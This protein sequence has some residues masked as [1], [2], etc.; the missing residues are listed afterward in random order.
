MPLSATRLLS[1]GSLVRDPARLPLRALLRSRMLRFLGL[2]LLAMPA[3]AATVPS[4]VTRPVDT[5]LVTQLVQH[6]PAWANPANLAAAVPEDQNFEQMTLVLARPAS[7]QAAL[8]QFLAEVQNPASPNYHKWLTAEEIGTRFG[9]SDD[10]LAAVTGWLAG[11][12]LHVNDLAPT[13]TLIRFGGTAGNIGR[14]FHTQLG[15]YNL[16]G[17]QRLSVSSDPSIPQALAPVIQAVR[18]LFAI[19]ERPMHSRSSLALAG[20][21]YTSSSSGNHYLTPADFAT[22]YDIPATYTGAGVTIGIVSWARVYSGDL[23]AF[24][25]RTATTFANPT[26]VIPTQYG[27]VDPGSPYSTPPSSCP[28]DCLGGQEE[29]TLDVIRAGG[30][31]QGANLLLVASSAS[32]SNDGIGADAQY[33][34]MQAPA[35]V[36]SISFG[37]C[38][39]SAGSSS[40]AY[41]DNLFSTAAAEGISVFVSSDDSGAAG[42]DTAFTTLPGTIV[43]NSPNY[44]CSSQYATCVG[45]TEFA[46]TSTPSQYWSSSNGTGNKSALSYI[47]E[48][49]WN[50]STTAG[51]AGTGGGVSTIVATPSWQNVTGVPAAR[52]GRY[53]PDVAFSAASH[54]GY[55]ACLAAANSDCTTYFA[56]F[57]GTSAA[58]PGMAGIAALLDQK[59]G[60]GQGNL[61]PVLYSKFAS[62]PSAFHDVTPTTS[63]VSNCSANA[64]SICNNSIYY[65]STGA[66]QPGFVVTT[67][68]DE[69]TGLGSLDVANF[70]NAFSPT[71]APTVTLTPAAHAITTAQALGISVAVAGSNG[72]PT[73][74][75]AV[76]NNGT[77]LLTND[78][79]SNGSV[80]LS[81]PAGALAAGTASLTA[82]YTPDTNS[83]ALYSTASSAAASI[84]VSKA[85]PAVTITPAYNSVNTNQT[86]AVLIGVSAGTGTATAT[87]TVTL[88]NNA[89][90]VGS[91]TLS[92]GSASITV[93]AGALAGGT[94]SLTATYTPDTA[95]ATLYN[96][97]SSAAASVT[98]NKVAP[99]V[100]VS[101]ATNP[102]NT[103]QALAVSVSVSAG[104]GT[105][106]ATGSVTLVRGSYASGTVSLANGAASISIPAASLTAGTASFTASYTP[107]TAGATL[108]NAATSAAVSETINKVAPPLSITLSYNTIVPAE[109]LPVTITA[110]GGSGTPT[111]TG[112]VT[113]SSGSYSAN[114]TLSSG[115]ASFVI[116]ANTFAVGA[117]TLSASYSPD[118]TSSPVYTTSSGSSPLTVAMVTPTVGVAANPSSITTQQSTAVTVTVAGNTGNPVPTG[119][120]TLTS[121]S[122][123][124]SSYPLSSGAATVSI[125]AGTLPL[126]TATVSATY[127][128][129]AN[130]TTSFHTASGST[131]IGVGLIAPTLTVSASPSSFTTLQ[132]T[133][134]SVAASGGTGNPAVTGSVVLTSG[135][136]T[137][138]GYT[139][140]SGTTS[141]PIPAGALAAG[142]STVTATYTPDSA[143]AANYKT[144]TGATSVNI[145]K[146]APTVAVSASPSSMTTLQ[147]ATIT[148]VVS[149]GSGA[150]TATGSVMLTS[151]SYTSAA[152]NLNSGVASIALPAGAVAAGSPTVTAT[153]TPD[154][155]GAVTYTASTGATSL[156]VNKVTPAVT[157]TPATGSL[158]V[159]QSLSVTVAVAGGTGTT[160]ATG[161]VVL[162]GGGYTSAAVALSGGSTTIVIPGN[163]LTAAT[164]VAL[165]ATYT[166]DTAGAAAYNASAGSSTVTVTSIAAS[167]SPSSVSQ[168]KGGSST[169]TITVTPSFG[170]T[171]QVT[172]TA[173]VTSSPSGA[174]Y[175]PS[176]SFGST[177]PVTITG[178]GPATA[179]LTIST[180]SASAA[181]LHAPLRPG[182]RWSTAGGAVLACLVLFSL[183]ARRRG[184][185]NLLGLLTLGMVLLAGAASCGGGSPTLATTN[186]GTTSGNYTLTVYGNN[187]AIGTVALTVQ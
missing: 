87:G 14:A 119:A 25:S 157:V 160:A 11:Q 156:T 36:I 48:G 35:Q 114:A 50:E 108:Y 65:T 171:G 94:A 142:S 40:V 115:A 18:G 184:W 61:N 8:E 168:S 169:T 30:T 124:S 98:V 68:F 34:V 12:G 76:Y 126:G 52:S 1:V 154:A 113:L 148:V 122:Y 152:T 46:D 91:A 103:T 181:A 173:Q 21:E 69:A 54:D 177:S 74:S 112:T 131:T 101:P 125:P 56:I 81:I 75:I 77:T 99:T 93:A 80:N 9:P 26:V 78:T 4:L 41:W 73:G 29:A 116:P 134:V 153:Y 47:P 167:A 32:G 22:I 133:S 107:D 150:P 45:G 43:A 33:L 53:T 58:A 159:Y 183:P 3:G 104:A 95:G 147:G 90:A 86:L 132:G 24:R 139:L 92:T 55:L 96:T 82:T 166:P 83:T 129:D 140:S 6:H 170:F 17:K 23:D 79:L 121:G 175:P 72:T 7:Q 128:P 186:S 182:S 155:A 145:S 123:S 138:A 172:L 44:I 102:A 106:I 143:G 105:A 62:S 127:T 5:G 146:V 84:A 109:S 66:V 141:I 85:T 38:E 60:A 31:A 51:I 165:T 130:S 100:T 185:R 111:V 187:Y 162:T 135:S 144:S 42:C 64:V 149:G 120:I 110:S 28:N 178:T 10:D 118:S 57:S 164:N 137:S 161:S 176:L 70:L 59:Q 136:Y 71:A 39:A 174:Q 88:S 89:T 117:P 13:R 163:S 151:G 180:T 16:E 19:G 27:G 37:A 63:G 15:Y 97:A 20:P 179:T 49:A 2:L 158:P 67:G